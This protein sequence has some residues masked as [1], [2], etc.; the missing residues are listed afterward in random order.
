D[1]FGEQRRERG[2]AGNSPTAIRLDRS[3]IRSTGDPSGPPADKYRAE[4]LT[5]SSAAPPGG[6]LG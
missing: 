6:R 4:A 1:A 2:H 5:S 3:E